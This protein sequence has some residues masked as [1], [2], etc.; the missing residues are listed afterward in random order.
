MVC[1]AL[2]VLV[3]VLWPSRVMPAEPAVPMVR[4]SGTLVEIGLDLS[5]ILIEEVVAW[6]GLGTGVVRRVIR[7]TPRTSIELIERPDTQGWSRPADRPGWH[8][9]AIPAAALRE[10][11]FVTVI[12]GDDRRGIAGALHV[13]RPATD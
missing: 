2:L 8:A 13:V 12:S 6:T 7:L 4:H 10:G 9:T 11:D 1:I 5:T 3:T